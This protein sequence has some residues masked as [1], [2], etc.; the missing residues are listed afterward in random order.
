MGQVEVTRKFT[1]VDLNIYAR[2]FPGLLISPVCAQSSNAPGNVCRGTGAKCKAAA[3][4][5]Q[6]CISP[7]ISNPYHYQFDK[8]KSVR[9]YLSPTPLDFS[10]SIRLALAGLNA[11]GL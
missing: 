8:M 5:A 7:A 10:V 2:P 6:I 9:S 1:Y 4:R 3:S 11:L